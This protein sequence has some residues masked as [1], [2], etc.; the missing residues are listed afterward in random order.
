MILTINDLMV[1]GIIG[2]SDSI[3]LW[4]KGD[5]L[6]YYSGL[7]SDMYEASRFKK[8]KQLIPG[9]VGWCVYV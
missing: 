2:D 9:A 6:P 1:S 3:V 5:Y 7:A 4:K 8:I